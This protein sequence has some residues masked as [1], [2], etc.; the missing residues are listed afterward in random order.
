[1]ARARILFRCKNKVG[2][3]WDTSSA[4]SDGGFDILS[5]NSFEDVALNHFFI[6]IECQSDS[7]GG[8]VKRLSEKIEEL[9]SK[10]NNSWHAV[11]DADLRKNVA[12]LVSGQN[13]CLVEILH[14][15]RSSKLDMNIK[16]V[17]SNYEKQKKLADFYEV[18]FEHVN[19]TDEE[20]KEN[21]I[22]KFVDDTDFIILARYMQVLSPHFLKSYGKPIINVH[23]SLCQS[24]TGEKHMKKPIPVASK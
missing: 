12:I 15:W 6:R 7:N 5:Y 8:S 23:H 22:L 18:K 19:I 3:V 16:G 14:L 9:A 17:I 13:H 2:L 21:E 1:M 24:L 11:F 10:C 4:V 20:K